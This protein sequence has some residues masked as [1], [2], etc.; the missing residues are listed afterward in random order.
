MLSRERVEAVIRHQ[1]PDRVPFYGWV[2]AN[3]S[4]PIA[5]EFGSVE[6]FEDK[7][8]FDF[9]HLFGGPPCYAKGTLEKLHQDLGRPIAPPDLLTVDVADPNDKDSYSSIVKDIQHH[10][11]Q[12]GRFVYVQTPGFF[13]AMNGV[14]GI[15]NHLAARGKGRP[16]SGKL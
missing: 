5:Q 2:K 14:F 12:R 3:L 1:K 10:K 11:E 16:F 15:E 9:V 8:E 7:Y 13:E 4:D 6:A